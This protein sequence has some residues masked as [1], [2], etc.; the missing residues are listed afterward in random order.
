MNCTKCKSD[1]DI[2][3]IDGEEYSHCPSCKGLLLKKD[4][5]NRLLKEQDD[6]ELHS[7]REYSDNQENPVTCPVCGADMK[8]INFLGFSGIVLDHCESCGA[9]WLD[10]GEISQMS[11]LITLVEE[12][13]HSVPEVKA[14][15]LLTRLSEIAYSV[16]H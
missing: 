11:E 3:N 4:Q 5:L 13:K 8:R 1:L 14:Y 6:V 16:F 10:K 2:I 7:I 15:N 12:G 9:F